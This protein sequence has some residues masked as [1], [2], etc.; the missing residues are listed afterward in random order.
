[1]IS[2]HFGDEHLDRVLPY[3]IDGDYFLNRN[4]AGQLKARV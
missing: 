2:I 1:L 3:R 4:D